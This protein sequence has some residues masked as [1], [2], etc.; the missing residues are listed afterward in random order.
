MRKWTQEERLRQSELI[1][2]WKPWEQSSGP[3][4]AEGKERVSFNAQTHGA[5]SRETKDRIQ[6]VLKGLRETLDFI[7]K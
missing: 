6:G 2:R 4:T 7:L 1:Q 5:Y 3:K